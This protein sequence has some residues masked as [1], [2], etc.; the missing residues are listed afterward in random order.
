MSSPNLPAQDATD[1]LRPAVAVRR[2]TLAAL[3]TAIISAVFVDLHILAVAGAAIW[4]FGS[5]LHFGL[6][7][8]AAVG[9]IIGAP[10][11]WACWK[12]GVMA[13][14]AERDAQD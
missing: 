6:V 3:F 13:L 2:L 1:P 5:T 8:L 12:I 11:L 14:E 4:A 7:G 10:A 9:A